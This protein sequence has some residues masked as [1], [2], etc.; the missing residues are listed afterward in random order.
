MQNGV[1]LEERDYFKDPFSESELRELAQ[2]VGISQMFARRS[3]S[4]KKLGL[5]DKDLSEG[6]MVSLMLQEPRLVRRPLVLMDGKLLVGANLK[7]VEAA[8]VE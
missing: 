3:P 2:G 7:A 4:L 6:E 8:L 1:Q 5:A